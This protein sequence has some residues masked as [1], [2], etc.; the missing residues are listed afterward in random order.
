MQEIIVS[1][2]TQCGTG[3]K[4]QAAYMNMLAN[5]ELYSEWKEK[6]A[7]IW[8]QTKLEHVPD[9]TVKTEFKNIVITKHSG[10]SKL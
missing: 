3:I 8:Y 6:M 2:N 10:R 7:N 1:F 5:T 9:K 4:G